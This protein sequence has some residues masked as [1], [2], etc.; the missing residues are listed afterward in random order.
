[1]QECIGYSM[2]LRAQITIDILAEDFRDAA[3]H[4]ARVEGLMQA[5]RREYGQASLEFRERRDRPPR[6]PPAGVAPAR[7]HYTG[8]LHEYDQ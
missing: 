4:Q 7:L 8:R 2:K 3:E 5:V 1:V 6:R